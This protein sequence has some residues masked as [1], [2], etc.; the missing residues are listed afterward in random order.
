M[1][2][3]LFPKNF[4]Y[5]IKTPIKSNTSIF[6]LDIFFS[7]PKKIT[8][9]GSSAFQKNL[10]QPC[11]FGLGLRKFSLDPVVVIFFK[12]C[13]KNYKCWIKCISKKIATTG[14]GNTCNFFWK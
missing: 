5:G 13:K 11:P 14:S 12:K 8:S 10:L 7:F 1:K 4:K 9:V 6:F 2:K 3:E